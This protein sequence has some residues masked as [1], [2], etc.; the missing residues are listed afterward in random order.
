MKKLSPYYLFCFAGLLVIGQ[1]LAACYA[2]KAQ[3]STP[4]PTATAI[5]PR[6]LSLPN[7]ELL[8]DPRVTINCDHGLG[9]TIT[10]SRQAIRWQLDVA[11]DP[12]SYAR[13]SIRF[14]SIVAP[15][16]GN[17]T[18]ILRANF[19]SSETHY[20]YLVEQNGKRFPMPIDLIQPRRYPD[21]IAIPLREVHDKEGNPPDFSLINEVQLVF[22]YAEFK[23]S[24]TLNSLQFVP[25]WHEF[26][27]VGHA[28]QELASKLS[29]PAGFVAEPAADYLSQM[30][31]LTFTDNGDLLVS[32][33]QGQIWWY[34]DRDAQGI[35]QQR[36]LWAA[37]F[38]EV[39]G[40]LYDPD[41]SVWV[42]GRGK[43]Y[44]TV[45]SDSDGVADI[46]ETRIEGLPWG[47][48]QNNSLAWNPDPD[49]FT[50]EAGNHWIYFGL[51]STDDLVVGGDQNATVLRFPRNGESA[52]DLQVVSRGNRNAYAVLWAEVPLDLQTPDAATAWRLFASENGPD[53][54]DA[55]DEVNHIR[56][57]HDYGFPEQFGNVDRESQEGKPYSSPL[58][59]VA[60][61]ASADGLAYIN[62]KQWPAAYQTLYV[63]L[64]GEIFSE[65]KV[66]HVVERISLTPVQ[67]AT[68]LTYRGEAETFIAGLERPL[69]LASDPDGNL[70]VGDYATGILYRI[71]YR[72]E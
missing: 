65:T 66:G 41:G 45:D 31:Q 18:L 23:E 39:V 15:L 64:F 43:L 46:Y 57:Q 33:Q 26:V 16:T 28:A 44:R 49:P 53:F 63:S 62:N 56:W 36:H 22:E 5:S 10:C 58:Y 68:G 32:L 61:H 11:S 52:K 19:A 8:T 20:L 67:L 7:S 25:V 48:H 29:V 30:T 2:G 69:P 70:L 12:S 21:Q 35:Y 47:R 51:G 6:K 55:P 1:L 17:E 71:R 37:G 27:N 50:G 14:D 24:V 34:S 13:M 38:E 3:Q 40:L 60:A 4:A 72:G 59:A 9:A 42:G 54:N